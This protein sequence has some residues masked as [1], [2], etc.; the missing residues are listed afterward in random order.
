ME[1]S[2]FRRFFPKRPISAC[3]APTR[4]VHLYGR[5]GGTMDAPK[6]SGSGSIRT[7]AF[8]WQPHILSV[9]TSYLR[10]REAMP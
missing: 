8:A 2:T 10:I 4:R 1:R 6:P 9:Y 5:V 3:E 7:R